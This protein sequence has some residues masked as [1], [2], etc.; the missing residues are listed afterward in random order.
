MTRACLRDKSQDFWYIFKTLPVIF[1]MTATYA[2]IGVQD[3][4][5]NTWGEGRNHGGETG[6]S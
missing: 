5:V 1:S 4:P 6:D 2:R 3:S